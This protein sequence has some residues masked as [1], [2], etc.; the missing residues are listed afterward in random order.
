MMNSTWEQATE[1]D[2]TRAKTPEFELAM[3]RDFYRIMR[4]CDQESILL[5]ELSGNEDELS[6]YAELYG[7]CA[8]LSEL[9][10]YEISRRELEGKDD[11]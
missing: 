11:E 5:W 10:S 4:D 6:I 3:L 8:A 1:E 2:K 7:V 9:D